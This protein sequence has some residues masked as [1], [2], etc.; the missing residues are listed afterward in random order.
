MEEAAVL[1]LCLL[2][3]PL[4]LLQFLWWVNKLWTC[5]DVIFYNVCGVCIFS[6][7]ADTMK[8]VIQ[9]GV[10][11]EIIYWQC[12]LRCKIHTCCCQGFLSKHEQIPPCLWAVC[13]LFQLGDSEVQFSRAANV[14]TFV[15]QTIT[16][17]L[18]LK[19]IFFNVKL[20]QS[21]IFV[22][23]GSL[24]CFSTTVVTNDGF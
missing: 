14:I 8:Y 11:W 22:P 10:C 15:G 24:P 2:C 6:W 21:Q 16:G 7:F 5:I 20:N 13:V 3:L 23:L 12:R 4:W 17:C 18:C 1:L 9:C 19:R